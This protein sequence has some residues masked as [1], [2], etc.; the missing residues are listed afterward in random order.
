M[1]RDRSGPSEIRTSTQGLFFVLDDNEKADELAA[2]V[3][4]DPQLPGRPNGSRR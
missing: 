4:L 2:M 3:A 1:R